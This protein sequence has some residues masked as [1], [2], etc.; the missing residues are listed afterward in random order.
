MQTVHIN[1]LKERNWQ[2]GFK[3][4]DPAIYCLQEI[5]FT[6]NDIHGLKVKGWENMYHANIK[7]N[8]NGYIN[9]IQ[10]SELQQQKSPETRGTPTI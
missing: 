7:E 1:Q 2:T 4:Y 5:N 3:N 9:I 6:Y 10:T 8:T